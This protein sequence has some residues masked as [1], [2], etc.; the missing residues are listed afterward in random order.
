ML[1]SGEIVLFS[2]CLCWFVVCVCSVHVPVVPFSP[3][4][5]SDLFLFCSLFRLSFAPALVF[6]FSL[7]VCIFYFFFALL[8]VSLALFWFK[9]QPFFGLNPECSTLYAPD[10]TIKADSRMVTHFIF[11]KVFCT[12]RPC[13][14]ESSSLSG[15][16]RVRA[17]SPSPALHLSEPPTALR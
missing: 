16:R 14:Q 8:T 13:L 2:L 1:P 10:L 15:W 11:F 9:N 5:I 3:Q 6:L 17:A 4:L 12:V 7:P